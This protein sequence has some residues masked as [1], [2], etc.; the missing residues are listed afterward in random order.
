M[1]LTLY[2]I[3]KLSRVEVDVAHRAMT[4]AGA[5]DEMDAPVPAEFARGPNAMAYALAL[6]ISRKPVHFYVGLAGLTAF[7]A[8]LLIR[9]GGYLAQLSWSGHGG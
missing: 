3:A 1:S 2:L 5:Q 6:F 7:P 9:L 4:T 8:Y